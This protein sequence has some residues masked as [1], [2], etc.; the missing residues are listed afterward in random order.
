M[1][2]GINKQYYSNRKERNEKKKRQTSYIHKSIKRVCQ[3]TSSTIIDC[4]I[5][6]QFY[7]IHQHLTRHYKLSVL[8][9]FIDICCQQKLQ[10]FTIDNPDLLPKSKKSSKITW[11]PMSL[12]PKDI[13]KHKRSAQAYLICI[14]IQKIAMTGAS[15]FISC[16]HK[17]LFKEIGRRHFSVPFNRTKN[18]RAQV[19]GAYIPQ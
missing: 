17:Q 15:N 6:L 9:L 2:F 8:T 12:K 14:S 11:A 16:L 7:L 19:Q 5:I 18:S 3:P 10:H 13:Q 1:D 4:F